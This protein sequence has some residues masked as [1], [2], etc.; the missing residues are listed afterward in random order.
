M[1][2]LKLIMEALSKMSN[3]A[4][5]AFGWWCAK[6]AF[7]YLM[8]P[9]TFA[10]IGIGAYKTVLGAIVAH[11]N[12]T[13]EYERRSWEREM[14]R[15]RVRRSL[16][17]RPHQQGFYAPPNQGSGVPQEPD[18]LQEKIL[19]ETKEFKDTIPP[20][21]NDCMLN[22]YL[23]ELAKEYDC[24]IDVVQR[25]AAQPKKIKEFWESHDKWLDKQNRTSDKQAFA[26]RKT[27][28]PGPSVE[29][30]EEEWR[31]EF[32]AQLSEDMV[33]REKFKVWLNSIGKLEFGADGRLSFNDL[34][35]IVMQEIIIDWKSKHSRYKTWLKKQ[36]PEPETQDLDA[37]K[38]EI[39]FLAENLSLTLDDLKKIAINHPKIAI[40]WDDLNLT[41]LNLLRGWID[42]KEIEVMLARLEEGI[43]PE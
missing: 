39:L 29:E 35:H 34:D 27:W 37:A 9:V 26:R 23:K 21:T 15:D 3:G 14:E 31:R 36:T 19:P 7:A 41:Q 22:R 1:D 20:G 30:A 43:L 38:K 5:T 18:T 2:E 25:N 40:K 16:N 42:S 11:S 8:W 6:E 24:T 32:E 28:L 33:D 13:K 10:V 4:S 17:E 12:C